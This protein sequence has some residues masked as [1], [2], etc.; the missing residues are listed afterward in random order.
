MAESNPGAGDQTVNRPSQ[1][2][3]QL[4]QAGRRPG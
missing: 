3:T 2:R 1:S 4:A